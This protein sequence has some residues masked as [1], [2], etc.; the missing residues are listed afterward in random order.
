MTTGEAPG[1]GVVG[2][3]SAGGV[4]RGLALLVAT[5]TV[6]GIGVGAGSPAAAHDDIAG[7]DPAHRSL[8]DEPISRVSV[9]FGVGVSDDTVMFLVYDRGDGTFEDIGGETI[10]TGPNTADLVF[11]ELD[12]QGT[13]TVRY[14][15]PVPI[16][17]HVIQGSI[18]FTWGVPTGEI[19]EDPNLLRVSPPGRAVLAEPISN[20]TLTFIDDVDVFNV[21]LIYDEGDGSSFPDVASDWEQTAPDTIELTF[22][23]LEDEGTYFIAYQADSATTGEEFAGATS[24]SIGQVSTANSGEGFPIVAFAIAAA[25]ILALGA[26][27]TLALARRAALAA[28]EDD[29]DDDGLGDG[30]VDPSDPD[31]EAAADTVSGT[32]SETGSPDHA[33]DDPVTV[34]R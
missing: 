33:G 11:D 26:A 22:D 30:S 5:L 24:F 6:I 29:G 4:L 20:A 27:G 12:R 25:A 23:P 3:R 16:D 8:I 28:D 34:T 2:R 1:P 14:I 19:P 31:D 10:K 15:A 18:S 17:A 21:R 9:D 7:S 13:Y 32:G